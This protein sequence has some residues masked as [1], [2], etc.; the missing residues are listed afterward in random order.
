M[1][2]EFGTLTFMAR[3]VE[4]VNVPPVGMGEWPEPDLD[5]GVR[6]VFLAERLEELDTIREWYPGGRETSAY[7][8]INGRL[9][10][11]LYQVDKRR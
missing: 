2:W 5:R 9:L 10:Y 4:G 1:Y 6:F 7:S 3:G 11:V 8:N